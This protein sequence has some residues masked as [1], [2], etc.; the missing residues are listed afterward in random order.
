MPKI[1]EIRREMNA[2]RG[3]F[4]K[5]KHILVLIEKEFRDFYSSKAWILTLFFPLFIT[6]LFA[7][8]YRQIE[9][10]PFKIG[11]AFQ[12]ESGLEQILASPE[13]QIIRYPG[14]DQAQKGLDAQEID[15]ILIKGSDS[16][17]RFSLRVPGN[18]AAKASLLVNAFNAALVQVYSHQQLPQIKLELVGPSRPLSA[19]ALPLWLIQILLTVCLLQNSAQ[20]AEE[21]SKATLH[22]FL[23]S[24]AT[25]PEYLMAKLLWNVF[26]G[27]ASVLLTVTLTRFPFDPVQLIVFI[28]LG[29]M[30]YASIALIIGLL[31]PNALFAR[32]LATGFYLISSLPLMIKNTSIAWKSITY[33]FP[34]FSIQYGLENALVQTAW[35]A[36]MLSHIIILAIETL[37]LLSI[38]YYPLKK[39]FPF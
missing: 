11:I 6:F 39:N 16:P 33:I 36:N 21:K 19:L 18:D 2:F 28:I 13:L 35:T 31:A 25:L 9:P 37:G 14:I 34:T 23:L 20:I 12:P 3:C 1:P 4:M 22:A 38:T 24:P 10:Q 29:S 7:T 15:G 27:T 17:H 8:V 30:V 26:I 5:L 32:T